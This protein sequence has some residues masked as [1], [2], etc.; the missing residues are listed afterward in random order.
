MN[1]RDKSRLAKAIARAPEPGSSPF[2]PPREFCRKVKKLVS[3][4]DKMCVA[5]LRASVDLD[6]A[7]KERTNAIFRDEEYRMRIAYLE[8]KLQNL[9]YPAD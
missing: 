6:K 4:H 7:N 5:V 1:K 2:A 3:E 9:G 8:K